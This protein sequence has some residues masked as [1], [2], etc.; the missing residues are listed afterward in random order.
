[1]THGGVMRNRNTVRIR[2]GYHASRVEAGLAAGEVRQDPTFIKMCVHRQD[3][4]VA[5]PERGGLRV[6]S[7]FHDS[8]NA[9][10]GA[11]RAPIS[12]HKSAI[13]RVTPGR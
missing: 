5:N 13:P 6:L 10:D 2:G 9:R 8:W 4:E 3:V 12:H 7:F 1:M 11:R